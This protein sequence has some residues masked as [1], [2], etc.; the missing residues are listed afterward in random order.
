LRSNCVPQRPWARQFDIR[1]LL[2]LG[3]INR[4]RLA[5]ECKNIR[6]NFPLVVLTVQRS[7]NESY[8][9]FISSHAPIQQEF[10][11]PGVE[12]RKKAGIGEDKGERVRQRAPASIYPISAPIGKSCCQVG[13]DS[14]G[15]DV[16]PICGPVPMRAGGVI[17]PPSIAG[18]LPGAYAPGEPNAV[19][20]YCIPSC[21]ALPIPL[22]LTT[23]RKSR[24]SRIHP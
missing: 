20:M 17:K 2:E 19:C 4:V 8:H 1:G 11:V 3:Q 23:M 12:V 9:E 13:R 24:Y 5:V 6:E 7:V 16:T 18:G 10:S 21:V 14:N 15:G 22:L